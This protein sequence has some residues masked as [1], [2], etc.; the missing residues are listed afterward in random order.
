LL[1]SKKKDAWPACGLNDAAIAADVVKNCIS[2]P[3]T[4][5][6]P[7]S[8]GLTLPTSLAANSALYDRSRFVCATGGP[9]LGEGQ[10]RCCVV[11]SL[12]VATTA[13]SLAILLATLAADS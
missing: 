2:E 11:V 10:C 9:S 6:P 13:I 7:F 1:F 5:A 4:S 12:L 8:L 3:R